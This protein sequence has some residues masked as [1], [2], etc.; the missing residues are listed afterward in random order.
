MFVVI[1][2]IVDVVDVVDKVAVVD[3]LDT[4]LEQQSPSFAPEQHDSS[5][6]VVVVD[7]QQ[8]ALVTVTAGA[9][10]NEGVDGELTT[11]RVTMHRGTASANRARNDS[12]VSACSNSTS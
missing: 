10:V 9:A 1:V 7:A 4:C 8:R 3:E 2:V 5:F 11:S 6:F 12:L